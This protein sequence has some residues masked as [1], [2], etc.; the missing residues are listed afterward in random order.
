MHKYFNSN[1]RAQVW[2]YAVLSFFT[3]LI[4][5]Y[6]AD[7]KNFF[8]F[9]DLKFLPTFGLFFFFAIAFFEITDPMHFEFSRRKVWAN[10]SSTSTNNDEVNEILTRRK[11]LY[12]Y[13][14]FP[15]GEC[16][17]DGYI[18]K[19]SIG[20]GEYNLG[21]I[22]KYKETCSTC[23]GTKREQI[24]L[25]YHS[26]EKCRNCNGR[27]DYYR[28]KTIRKIEHIDGLKIE[29]EYITEI[30]EGPDPACLGSGLLVSYMSDSDFRQLV[31]LGNRVDCKNS[32]CDNGYVPTK[33]YSEQYK[34][35]ILGKE[36]C[37]NCRG[38]GHL[39]L[40]FPDIPLYQ[41][42]V[43]VRYGKWFP[44]HGSRKYSSTAIISSK[45]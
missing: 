19:E 32:I 25:F 7:F 1:F 34:G 43:C 5:V 31:Q 44:W 37:P 36:K 27:K 10:I 6:L 18:V 45:D 30:N 41:F 22:T 3:W 33:T 8:Y 13:S 17:G 12:K 42:L 40:V 35:H 16:Y 11:L 20:Q 23:N 28:E 26:G 21:E 39:R 38:Y 14:S 29:K 24:H 9:G 4:F 15:C 2:P